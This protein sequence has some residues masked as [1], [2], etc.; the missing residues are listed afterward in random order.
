M[1]NG[2]RTAPYGYG[3]F[4][5]Y[6]KGNT[7]AHVYS[8]LRS[9]RSI[10]DNMIV[11]HLCEHKFCVNPDHLVTVS[12]NNQRYYDRRK[13]R[14][15]NATFHT[16]HENERQLWCAYIR[17]A[18]ERTSSTV[19]INIAGF[20]AQRQ[21]WGGVWKSVPKKARNYFERWKNEMKLLMELSDQIIT[22]I[23][24]E[25]HKH[26]LQGVPITRLGIIRLLIKEALIMRSYMSNED[27]NNMYKLVLQYDMKLKARGAIGED[28][29]APP[30]GRK[31]RLLPDGTHL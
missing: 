19:D 21:Y 6:E 10:P 26:Q 29:A 9:G 20:V 8:V 12:E 7:R 3:I 1:W 4:Y 5:T 23:E 28:P 30:D 15:S 31:K 13:A 24:D 11:D 25:R 16:S 17:D 2:K 18:Q 27:R 22:D 14:S